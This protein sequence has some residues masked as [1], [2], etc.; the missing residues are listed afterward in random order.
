MDFSNVQH[1]LL[2]IGTKL[3]GFGTIVAVSDTAYQVEWH[4]PCYYGTST[5]REWV[6]FIHIH[7]PYKMETPLV[8]F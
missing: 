1:G 5:R 3:P 6:G 7:G 4:E 2:P 8:V